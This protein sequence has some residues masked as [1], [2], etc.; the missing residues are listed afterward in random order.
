M[1]PAARVAAAIE[2]LDSMVAGLAAEQA[3]TRWARASR[4]AGSKDRAAVRDHVFSV[5][6]KRETAA[7]LGGGSSGRA[8]MIGLMRAEGE[9]VATFFTGEGHAPAP[10]TAQEN[11]FL[12]DA[13]SC[14]AHWNLPGW[15]VPLFEASLGK[16]AMQAAQALQHRAPTSL[17]VNTQKTTRDEAAAMLA[18]DGIE[19]VPNRLAETA[20]TVTSGE[21]RVKLSHSYQTGYVELQDAASQAVVLALPDAHECLDYCAGGGGKALALEATGGR[22]VYA[23]DR[24][25]NRMRDLDARAARAGSAIVQIET[26]RL[27]SQAPFDLVLCD[28]PCS[29]SGAW[30]RSP[31]AKWGFDPARL[32]AL[33]GTQDEIL[34]HAAALVAQNGTLAYATCSVLREENEDSIASFLRENP[35]WTCDFQQRF[36][37]CAEGDGFYTAHLTRRK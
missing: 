17:R 35:V 36:D 37:V 24:D 34:R 12:G 10:L 25:A 21:R 7:W 3:L 20:L 13:A 4:F 28:V 14:E 32:E 18:D 31:E 19:T 6:R 15:L 16:G 33:C 29:G 1:T 11:G 27:E 9:V 22:S 8:L 23:H 30:R 2:I 26:T 5:L